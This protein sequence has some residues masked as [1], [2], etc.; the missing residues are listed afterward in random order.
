M[1]LTSEGYE[2]PFGYEEAIGYM[3]GS[4]IRDKDGVSATVCTR[5]SH[6]TVLLNLG[7]DGLRRDDGWSSFARQ[8]CELPFARSVQ[9]VRWFGMFMHSFTH[10]IC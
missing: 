2:V 8:E 5:T 3:F 1:S 6:A 9:T 7:A 4:E 10:L